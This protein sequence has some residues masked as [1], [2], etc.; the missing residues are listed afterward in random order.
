MSV[1]SGIEPILTQD[2]ITFVRV[3]KYENI[4]QYIKI[5]VTGNTLDFL[6]DFTINLLNPKVKIYVNKDKINRLSGGGGSRLNINS[7][8]SADTLDVSM[9]EGSDTFGKVGVKNFSIPMSGGSRSELEG[10]AEKLTLNAS[11]GS[12]YGNFNHA[13]IQSNIRLSRGSSVHITASYF[14]SLEGSAEQVCNTKA[15]QSSKLTF[16]EGQL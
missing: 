4:H 14:L 15:T 13:I 11:C 2:S 5:E 6:I 8:W 16:L 3:E 12:S 9:N 1:S 10:S 7:G